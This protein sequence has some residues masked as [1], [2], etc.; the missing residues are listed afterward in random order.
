MKCRDTWPQV[1]EMPKPDLKARLITPS[2][3]ANKLEC[4]RRATVLSHS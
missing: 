1:F 3:G 2:N 4:D